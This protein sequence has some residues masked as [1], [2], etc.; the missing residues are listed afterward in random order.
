MS[1][2]I[3]RGAEA[4]LYKKGDILIK[5]RIKKGYRIDEIDEKLRLQRTKFESR[6]MLRAR[7]HG[8]NVPNVIKTKEYKIFMEFINGKRLKEFLN[9][10]TSFKRKEISKEIG[11]N[12]GILHSAGIVH[13]DLTTSNMILKEKDFG[14]KIPKIE[15]QSQDNRKRNHRY[16]VYFIDFGLAFHSL[17]VE[18]RA[19]DLH[20]LHQAYQSTHFKY[21]EE[22]WTSTLEGYKEMFEDWKN[23]L[24]RLKQIRK[25]GRY[26]KR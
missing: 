18:D 16:L 22:L 12:I 21:I 13:G 8:I 6:I 1:E 14:T 4:I 17:S 11:R 2:I 23:V 15:I 26:S 19:I 20:L 5:E 25:R 10:T 7:R 3:G 9:K 24:S